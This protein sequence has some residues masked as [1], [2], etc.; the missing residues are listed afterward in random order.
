MFPPGLEPGTFRVLGERDNHYT[1]ETCKFEQNPKH[2]FH[3]KY[4]HEQVSAQVKKLNNMTRLFVEEVAWCPVNTAEG[5]V[6]DGLFPT[7][8]SQMAAR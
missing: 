2:F 5:S 6:P 7:D 1:T 3:Q 8:Y 4:P